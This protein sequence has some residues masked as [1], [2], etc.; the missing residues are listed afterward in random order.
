MTTQ[1]AISGQSF[2][3]S[4]NIGNNKFSIAPLTLADATTAIVVNAQ[5]TNGA[6]PLNP[7]A[8]LVVW[9][10]T[11]MRT[12]S[13]ANAPFTLKQGA[14]FVVVEPHSDSSK[15]ASKNS[16]LA[17]KAGANF[18]C[19]VDAPTLPTAATLSVDVVELPS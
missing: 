9:F 14:E 13:A 1:S 11:T 8:R 5:W 17:I 18:H 12:V 6:G 19:W 7:S 10:N 3:T 4:T 2:G 15:I 16:E